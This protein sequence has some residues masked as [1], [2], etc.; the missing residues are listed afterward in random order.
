MV[1]LGFRFVAAPRSYHRLTVLGLRCISAPV[2]LRDE[3]SDL[4]IDYFLVL[5]AL[6]LTGHSLG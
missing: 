4:V 2:A 5:L 6:P 1:L 3:A